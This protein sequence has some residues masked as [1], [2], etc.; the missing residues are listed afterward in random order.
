MIFRPSFAARAGS[1]VLTA[2]ATVT[3]L[4]IAGGASA[5]PATGA[6]AAARPGVSAV[7]AITAGSNAIRLTWHNPGR[8]G[9]VAT[10]VR[11]A[12]GT[13]APATPTDGLAGGRPN[14]TRTALTVDRLR[15]ATH[16]AF[17]LF[18][19]YGHG[20]YGARAVARATTAP[21]AVRL[22]QPFAH[23]STVTVTWRA[24]RAATYAATVVR[25][26]SGGRAPED[27][28][29]GTGVALTGPHA[30]SARLTG[31]APATTYAVA[32]WTRDRLGRY[33]SVAKTRFT[34]PAAAGTATG[35][36]TGTVTDDA[37]HPLTGVEVLVVDGDTAASWT[38]TT[39]GSGHY[40]I[41][42]P[43][44]SVTVVFAGDTAT[45]GDGDT[46]GYQPDVQDAEVPSGG[47]QTVNGALV[48]GGEIDG[49]VTDHLGNPLAGVGVSPRYPDSYAMQN[50]GF[51]IVSFSE[52]G[53]PTTD[54]DG[55]Y[56]LRGAPPVAQQVCYEPSS[57]PVTGGT[58]DAAGY[59]ARCEH[60]TVAAGPGDVR[61]L[62]PTALLPAATGTLTGV[63][64]DSSGHPL[65]GVI[66]DVEARDLDSFDGGADITDAAGRYRVGGLSRGSYDV[67]A[68]PTSAPLAP[69]S[70]GNAPTC[71]FAAATITRAHTTDT[72]VTLRAAGALGG[73]VRAARGTPLPALV[74]VQSQGGPTAGFGS[75]DRHGQYTV[76]D[77]A[78]GRYR[79][80]FL[81][82]DV[83]AGGS[84]P[85]CYRDGDLVQVRRGLTRL[86]VDASLAPGGGVSGHV[87]GIPDGSEVAV[88]AFLPGEEEPVGQGGV[89]PS[90]DYAIGGLPAG[91]YEICAFAFSDTGESGGCHRGN[92][93]VHV[94]HVTGGVGIALPAGGTLTTTVT[95]EA[96]RPV[97]GVDVAVLAPCPDGSCGTVPLFDAAHPANVV[98]SGMTDADGR[99]RLGVPPSGHYAV[100]ALTYY[101][102]ATAGD[103]ATSYL[104]TCTAHGTFG[105]TVRAGHDT[106]EAF[107]LH[108]AGAVSGRVTDAAG[109][110]LADVRVIVGQSSSSD[111]YDPEQ[112]IDDPFEVAPP[113]PAS[114]VLTEADGTYVVP[115]VQ[116]GQRTVCFDTAAAVDLTGTAHPHGLLSQCVGG[117]PGSDQGGTPVTVPVAATVSGVDQ[118]VVEAAVITGRIVDR[119][120]GRPIPHAVALL[121]SGTREIGAAATNSAGRYRL[122]GVPPG[123]VRVCFAAFGYQFQ[124]YDNV[125]WTTKEP[126]AKSTPVLT[127]S[128]GTVTLKDARLRRE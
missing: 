58:S 79:V 57:A 102:A 91:R 69:G 114:E 118:Q 56:Q 31:L 59:Q 18:T 3:G 76:P 39:D 24:P 101:G 72:D 11:Y 13:R 111:Y 90:G 125:P 63:V 78:P 119:R 32:I 81:P 28:H 95:N 55:R 124:C 121:L 103:P 1:A 40:A 74:V 29:A 33:S 106:A 100:C 84:Q 70:V 128:G 71:R 27:P 49:Q 43:A 26:A 109:H 16:Y 53:L 60:R 15:P 88:G 97:S 89:G 87:S 50:G 98:A 62:A 6:P 85:G 21:D 67:C 107:T 48:P 120:T 38:T 4:L 45:G 7:A 9:R 117:A 64:S 126:P 37:A 104:D 92:V 30:T 5:T 46:A 2:A 20:R 17:A 34:T 25:L 52:D 96:G 14:A 99:L 10:I 93:S 83:E 44:G 75:T 23:G 86:G 35:Q 66:V 77:L 8:S 54:A 115:G 42:V 73:R 112:F 68:D 51:F 22:V 12:A 47:T 36:L 123:S 80:C 105:I 41:T 108:P 82:F 122:A 116:P 65:A 19:S 61:T 127:T 113:G 110:S 94:G